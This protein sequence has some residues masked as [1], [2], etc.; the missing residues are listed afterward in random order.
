MQLRA[1]EGTQTFSETAIS[2]H[3]AGLQRPP[4][5]L[6]GLCLPRPQAPLG[7]RQPGQEAASSPP[8]CSGSFWKA[9]H[10]GRIHSSPCSDTTIR[11]WCEKWG[12]GGAGLHCLTRPCTTSSLWKEGLGGGVGGGCHAACITSDGD[13]RSF[14]PL[15]F[16]PRGQHT[17]SQPR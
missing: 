17:G 4:C 13:T 2:G 1:P 3:L 15:C 12:G 10:Q 8:S 14:R 11:S 5:S 16:Q 9:G 6:G 7:F